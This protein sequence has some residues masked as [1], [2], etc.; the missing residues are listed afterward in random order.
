[1]TYSFG[2]SA[3]APRPVTGGDLVARVRSTPDLA[4]SLDPDDRAGLIAALLSG[5]AEA[6]AD[7]IVALTRAESAL[8]AEDH[9]SCGQ[10]ALMACCWMLFMIGRIDDV[11]VV[12]AAKM[13]DFDTY[14]GI[15]SVFLLPHGLDATLGYAATHHLDDLLAW[16]TRLNGDLD[17]HAQS[18]RDTTYFD[19]R[20][21]L[22]ATVEELAAWIR[23]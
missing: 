3:E 6:D 19:E 13:T 7:L 4:E 20:P 14:C 15:D 23:G 2:D 21:G 11:P 5:F 12:F 22:D 18:W 10:D 9:I 8:L 16:I 1:M 17:A